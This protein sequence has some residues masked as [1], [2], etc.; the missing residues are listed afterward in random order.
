MIA[1]NYATPQDAEQAFYR[2]FELADLAEMMA[3]WSEEEDVVCVHPGGS[4]HSGVVDVRESWRQI[5]SQGPR[6]RFRLVG[7]RVFSGRMVSVHSVYEHISVA[8]DPR[9]ASPVLSTNVY[10]LTDR[11]WRMLVHHASQLAGEAVSPQES[12]PSVLH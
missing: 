9:P 8:G 7:N 1:K 10:V 12:P 4:R 11:G 3:V 5:F 6:L 2:A